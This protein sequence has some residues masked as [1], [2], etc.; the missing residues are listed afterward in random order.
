M[1]LEFKIIT[2]GRVLSFLPWRRN[3]RLIGGFHAKG[4]SC[5]CMLSLWER[6]TADCQ[7]SHPIYKRRR[8]LDVKAALLA[9]ATGR[10]FEIP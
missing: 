5:R 8:L 9:F 1:R 6:K 4:R 10:F 2:F 3:N 7:T